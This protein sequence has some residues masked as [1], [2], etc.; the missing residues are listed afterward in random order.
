MPSRRHIRVVGAMLEKES[1]RY[2]IT[3]RRKTAAL[4]LLWEFPGGRVH[5]GETDEA[6]LLREMK[7]RLGIDIV[8][9]AKAATTHHEYPDYDLDFSVFH[10]RLQPTSGPVSSEKVNDH[11]WVQLSEMGQYKFPDADARTLAKLLELDG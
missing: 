5:E 9:D 11:R 6:A 8:V 2:L 4:P 7:E 3:Q 1:G 10:C